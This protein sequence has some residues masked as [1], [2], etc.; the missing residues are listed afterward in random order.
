VNWSHTVQIVSNDLRGS[1]IE[2]SVTENPKHS[3]RSKMRIVYLD[4]PSYLPAKAIERIRQLGEFLVFD[5]LPTPEE[6]VHRLSSADVAIVEWTDITR[7][8]LMQ[9]P[10]LKY[11]VLVTTGYEFVDI[12]AARELGILVSNT[13]EYS[14]QS[15][16]EHIFG[17]FLFLAKNLSNADQIVRK[18]LGEASYT[19]QYIGTE[20]FDKTLS[21][22]GLG[23]IG[24]H[25]AQI[26]KGFGMR[27]LG[28]SRSPKKLPGVEE[29]PLDE[30]LRRGDFIAVCLSVNDTTI[31]LLNEEKLKLVQ[32][33]AIFVN[34]A[35]NS[36]LDEEIL[37][38]MLSTNRMR[39][40]GL[41]HVTGQSLL[42]LP[43]VALSPGTA[44]Y[45]QESL[46]RNVE[47]FTESIELFIDGEPRFLVN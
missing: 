8:M 26:G 30:V 27:I 23:S 35:S 36:V 20:L 42:N 21:I 34:I 25:V 22:L 19:S 15:V 1:M 2:F 33:S 41:D 9:C 31:G 46:D 16:A 24:S 28:F 38:K 6:A 37:S 3:R 47:M 12:A 13:P 45:T 44:W 17:Q 43:N 39:G 10:N 40:A 14:R 5:D 11:I 18:T 32:P 29:M 7:D 4:K